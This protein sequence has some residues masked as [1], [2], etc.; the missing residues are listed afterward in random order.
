[1][2]E[3]SVLKNESRIIKTKMKKWLTFTV[4]VFTLAVV[5]FVFYILNN[6]SYISQTEQFPKLLERSVS[7]KSSLK[8][9]NHIELENLTS[10]QTQESSN[11]DVLAQLEALK[12]SIQNQQRLED[13]SLKE[14]YDSVS[15]LQATKQIN[16]F[17]ALD[18]KHWLLSLMTSENTKLKQE[19]KEEKQ[20]LTQ[21]TMQAIKEEEYARK[22]DKQFLAYKEQEA[23]IIQ[24]VLAKHPDNEEKAAIELQKKLD[25]L[26][27]NIY[28]TQ[29]D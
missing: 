5:W 12:K 2:L 11:T 20:R 22:Q 13:E 6:Q 1:M 21:Q 7:D 17:H 25:N 27:A 9:T 19:L 16:P 4:V 18:I 24:E 15:Q 3:S 23:K 26:R 8:Q 29:Q 10:T 28:A 14:L